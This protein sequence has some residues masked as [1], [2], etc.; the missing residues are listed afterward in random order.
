MATQRIV[1]S[2]S[3]GF[4]KRNDWRGTETILVERSIGTRSL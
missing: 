4:R 3:R 1:P 2:L